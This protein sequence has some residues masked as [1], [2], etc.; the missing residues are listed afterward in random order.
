MRR[1]LTILLALSLLASCKKEE[2]KTEPAKPTTPAT[3]PAKGTPETPKGP[4]TP[5]P[6]AIPT[7]TP[8]ALAAVAD[9]TGALWALAPA[10]ATWGIVVGDGAAAKALTLTGDLLKA[11]ESKPFGKKMVADLRKEISAGPFDPF[12]QAAW[13]KAGL[14]PNK[15]AAVFFAGSPDNPVLAVL[16]VVDRAAFRTFAKGK[17]EKVGDKEYDKFDKVSCLDVNGR[18]LCAPKVE[19]LTAPAAAGPI[20]AAVKALPPDSRGDL[21]LYIDVD[22]TPDFA[23]EMEG[24]KELGKVSAVGGMAR[25]DS[26]GATVHF[27]GK[28]VMD[29]KAVKSATSRPLP[30]AM[31]NYMGGAS[32]VVRVHL[33]PD[34]FNQAGSD[35]P[36]E[37]A[38]MVKQLTGDMMFVTAGKGLMAGAIVLGIND[39]EKVGKGIDAACKMLAS[40]GATSAPGACSG[41]APLS[42]MVNPMLP[43]LKYDIRVDGKALVIT[44]GDVDRASLKGSVLSETGSKE[45]K[46]VLTGAHVFA[47]WTY[48]LGVDLASLPKE[49]AEMAAKDKDVGEALNV[50]SWLSTQV[51]EIAF[52]GG[53]D[54]TSAHL[55]VRITSFG[56]DPAEARAAYE[57]AVEKRIA[58]DAAGTK[59]ALADVVAKYPNTLAARRAKMEAAGT[60]VIGPA[61]VL[62]GAGMFLTAMSRS[63]AE[64]PMGGPALEDK[65]GFGAAP[66]APIK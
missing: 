20:A 53:I 47:G 30:P 1:C 12:D 46:D 44:L 21:E 8:L 4:E 29:G 48:G 5:A 14:D 31:A 23:K 13:K 39:G 36:P 50:L 43:D 24:L 54:A 37:I 10:D 41:T 3:T 32:S 16:P 42:A 15:G 65:G 51:Y 17:T 45:A 19:A 35:A 61:T 28:G 27:Y 58:G 34:L 6:G 33:S 66:P 59:A 57:K 25:F 64:P 22:K 18:Y 40:I 55:I 38:E 9:S 56:G 2:K 11:L 7:G 52:A 63:M 62:V 26:S 60:P 49:L